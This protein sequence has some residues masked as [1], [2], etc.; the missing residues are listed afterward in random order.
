MPAF[1]AVGLLAQLPLDHPPVRTHDLSFV[2]GKRL[3]G[4]GLARQDCAL[5]AHSRQSYRAIEQGM[6]ILKICSPREPIAGSLL[7]LRVPRNAL[8]TPARLKAGPDR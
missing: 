7:E 5:Q 6:I 1:N 2:A 3:N 4:R 8:D